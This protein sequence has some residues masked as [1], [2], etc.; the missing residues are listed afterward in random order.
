M[1]F[2]QPLSISS[3]SGHRDKIRIEFRNEDIFQ[4]EDGLPIRKNTVI[5]KDLPP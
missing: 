4:D 2:N 1:K 5:I 3:S